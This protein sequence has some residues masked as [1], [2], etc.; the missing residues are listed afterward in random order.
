MNGQMH[1]KAHLKVVPSRAHAR[2]HHGAAFVIAPFPPIASPV[3]THA[4]SLLH[5]FQEQN[6]RVISGAGP[7]LALAR[8]QFTFAA[9][10]RFQ[11]ELGPLKPQYLREFCVIYPGAI[12][13][14]RVSKPRWYQRR[15]EEL[16]RF[17]LVARAVL[18][19]KT[20]ALVFEERPWFQRDQIGFALTA[21]AVGVLRR[22]KVV[23]ARRTQP[24]EELFTYLTGFETASPDVDQ[25]EATA[26]DVAFGA[27]SLRQRLRL[28]TARAEQAA[29]YLVERD[30]G[31]AAHD[32]LA[33]VTQLSAATQTLD[34]RSMPHARMASFAPI[35]GDG[36]WARA[37]PAP[38]ADALDPM[39]ARFRMPI[40]RYMTQLRDSQN[41]AQQFPLKNKADA[42]KFL[43]WYVTE[44]PVSQPNN[45]VPVPASVRAFIKNEHGHNLVLSPPEPGIVT[46]VF[47]RDQ[48]PFALSE[49]LIAHAKSPGM[50]EK[51]DLSIPG[52]R[53]AFAIETLFRLRDDQD[54]AA[55]LGK[56][57]LRYFSAPVGGATGNLTRFEFL[58]ALQFRFELTGK[59]DV[60]Q[61]WQS[62]AI[63]RWL[64]SVIDE[65]FPALA[66]FVTHRPPVQP[67][68]PGLAIV[69][70]PNSS[71]G[72]GSNLHMSLRA[73][74]KLGLNPDVRDA[75]EHFNRFEIAAPKGV[76]LRLKRDV[77]LHH[78]NADRIPQSVI[79]P[80]QARMDQTAHVGF[81]LWEFDRIPQS[82]RLAIDMLD[83]IWVPSKF[84]RE[85]YARAGQKPVHNVLK[86]I[87]LPPVTACD[88]SKFGVPLETRVFLTCFDFHSSLS[89]KNPLA[90][91]RAFQNAFPTS[92]DVHLIIKTTPPVANHWGDPE[93][94]MT[95]IN[96]LVARDK[97][98]TLITD[99]LPFHE[100]L[101]LIAASDCLVS[102]HRAEGFGLMPAYAL[103]LGVP[104]MSTDYSGTTDFCTT[105]TSFP[106]A[107]DLVSVDPTHVLHPMKD[108]RWAEINIEHLA[109]TMKAFADDPLD[110][111]MRAV[112]G[113]KLIASRYSPSRHAERYR[114]RL[115][116]LGALS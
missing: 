71:T 59:S 112:R 105:E 114:K 5:M 96:E 88:L 103:G 53:I 1:Q 2:V 21:L 51:F 98:I 32:I 12:D 80:R 42:R 46:H 111:R 18:S 86:G 19:S 39:Y 102:T 3:A 93:G 28:T 4:S 63:R 87:Q 68:K 44:A 8:H 6:Y 101:A 62:P 99:H 37:Q 82:H 61:P 97:R 48:N 52:E 26:F 27:D 24:V 108:A 16:R 78:I 43:N 74:Q 35:Q 29:R 33:D 95:E 91:V 73:F 41:L 56:D 70:L 106:I 49:P 40:T 77:V 57:A 25:A 104:V 30:A 11:R 100:L 31:A 110:G 79:S 60:E 45:W 81:L 94:Q 54:G 10:S 65:K 20:T 116:A 15:L 113:K 36:G 90:A 13:F 7:G 69:G 17:R 107:Y 47:G 64:A 75:A 58:L 14:T 109:A 72:V 67:A 85:C 76:P 22:R 9:E 89:R 55:V 34:L 92:P 38:A 83:E 84:V 115:Q 23:F 66:G 50:R